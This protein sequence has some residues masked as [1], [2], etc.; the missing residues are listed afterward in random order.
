M[1]AIFR[2][3]VTGLEPVLLVS[4]LYQVRT[5]WEQRKAYVRLRGER[6]LRGR[7]LHKLGRIFLGFARRRMHSF[8]V[9]NDESIGGC[10]F[11]RCTHLT[12]GSEV[13]RGGVSFLLCW[14]SLM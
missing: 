13:L 4:P 5:D 10:R 9:G 7:R 3:E 12:G 6:G 1:R 11:G 14:R 2:D 8:D